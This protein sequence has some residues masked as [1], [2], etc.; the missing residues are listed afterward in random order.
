MRIFVLGDYILYLFQKLNSI[1]FNRGSDIYEKISSRYI[2]RSYDYPYSTVKRH[3]IEGDNSIFS[4]NECL[5]FHYSSFSNRRNI[6][7]NQF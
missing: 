3:R 1:K 7:S 5:S 2:Y 6:H 4:R